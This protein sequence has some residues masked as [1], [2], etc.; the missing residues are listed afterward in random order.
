MADKSLKDSA[1]DNPTA[2]G[3]PVSLKAEKSDSQPTENDKPNDSEDSK[4]S[5]KDIAEEDLNAAKKGNRSMLGDPV[6]LKAETSEKDP[7][8][9]EMGGTTDNKGRDSK[10]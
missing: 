2:M 9:D 5:L 4:K 6:S 1:K 10:L 8:E 3:D 7:A